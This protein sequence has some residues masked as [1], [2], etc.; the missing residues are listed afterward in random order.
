M[1]VQN[2]AKLPRVLGLLGVFIAISKVAYAYFTI[3][4]LPFTM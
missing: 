4:F 3:T 2:T 1:L